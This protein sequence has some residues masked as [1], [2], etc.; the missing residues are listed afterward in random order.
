MCACFVDLLRGRC[1]S[2][3]S[4]LGFDWTCAGIHHNSVDIKSAIIMVDTM[5]SCSTAILAAKSILQILHLWHR[6]F[7]MCFCRKILRVN[8]GFDPE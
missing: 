1:L 5:T 8:G 2:A 4:L 3:K 6:D 7:H